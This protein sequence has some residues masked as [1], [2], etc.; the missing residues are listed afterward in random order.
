[1]GALA[2]VAQVHQKILFRRREIGKK[3]PVRRKQVTW[4][5]D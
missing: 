3:T 1:M 4:R 5:V 2:T